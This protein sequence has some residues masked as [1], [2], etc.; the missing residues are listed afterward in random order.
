MSV[1]KTLSKD[2]IY[3][4]SISMGSVLNIHDSYELKKPWNH[5]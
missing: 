4:S 5:R 1:D 3:I 2:N